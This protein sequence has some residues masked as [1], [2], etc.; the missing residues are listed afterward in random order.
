MKHLTLFAILVFCSFN[1]FSQHVLLEDCK[2]SEVQL[3]ATTAL[4]PTDDV[5][6]QFLSLPIGRKVNSIEELT[7]KEI[8]K[9]K[10]WTK[11][12]GSC[13]AYMDFDQHAFNAKIPIQ[14]RENHLSYVI[15]MKYSAK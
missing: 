11:K 6:V 9:I 4:I 10:K 14:I 8:R 13:H 12:Q 3:H 1:S 5:R 15:A 2:K 7:E